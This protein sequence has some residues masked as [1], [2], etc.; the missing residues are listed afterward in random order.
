M[1]YAPNGRQDFTATRA[2]DEQP[3]FLK[4]FPSVSGSGDDLLITARY[5]LVVRAR[6][7]SITSYLTVFLVVMLPQLRVRRPSGHGSGE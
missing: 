4:E 2:R 3:T 7:Q 1:P 6:G 5:R